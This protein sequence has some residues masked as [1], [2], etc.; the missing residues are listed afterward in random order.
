MGSPREHLRQ[1]R[2]VAVLE[3]LADVGEAQERLP[4]GPP[5]SAT[6]TTPLLTL[7]P[8]ARAVAAAAESVPGESAEWVV[9]S[10]R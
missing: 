1:H 9:I 8:V 10:A 4:G 5:G 2:E 3:L 7:R 6:L